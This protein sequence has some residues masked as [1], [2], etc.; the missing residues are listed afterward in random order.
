MRSGAGRR[1][2][3]EVLLE[4]IA[5]VP[6]PDDARDLNLVHGK[7]HCRRAAALAQREARGRDLIDRGAAAAELPRDKGRQSLSFPQR[8]DRLVG[9]PGV[10]IDFVDPLRRHVVRDLLDRRE[11]GLGSAGVR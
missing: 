7:N 2:I 1:E 10:A 6:V 9:E 8:V 11:E 5:P 3:T 4:P